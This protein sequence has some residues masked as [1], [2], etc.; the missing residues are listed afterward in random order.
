M[1]HQKDLN[2]DN[3]SYLTP[4]EQEVAAKLV[5]KFANAKL[6][7]N[8]FGVEVRPVRHAYKKFYV[9]DKHK[10]E[11]EKDREQKQ[12]K[13]KQNRKQQL[14]EWVAAFGEPPRPSLNVIAEEVEL[15]GQQPVDMGTAQQHNSNGT[16]ASAN[17]E[18]AASI[19]LNPKPAVTFGQMSVSAASKASHAEHGGTT[20]DGSLLATIKTTEAAR[21]LSKG[22]NFWTRRRRVC[23]RKFCV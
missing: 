9:P 11:L 17:L 14:E 10:A 20:D 5:N 16:N 3:F 15:E 1:K 21:W 18:D 6:V 12:Q 4:K 23:G 7:A 19:H 13:R 8:L 2:P 22:R